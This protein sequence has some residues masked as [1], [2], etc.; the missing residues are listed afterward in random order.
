MRMKKTLTWIAVAVVGVLA[1]AGF[2]VAPALAQQAEDR[3]VDPGP[4]EGRGRQ[5]GGMRL[6]RALDL[7]DEQIEQARALRE[8][9][10]EESSG[11][12]DQVRAEVQA[13]VPRIRN[14]SLTQNDL[15]AAQRRI[16]DLMGQVGEQRA[17]TMYR[18]YQILTPEQRERLGT[19]LEERLEDGRGFGFGMFGDAGPAGAGGFHGRDGMHGPQA[20]RGV[21]DTDRANARPAPAGS[22]A[23]RG[24]RRAA[25]RNGAVFS[26]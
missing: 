26:R 24:E 12:R 14:G 10:R 3:P 6:I 25:G 15:V 17:G 4:R 19:L 2:A 7:T 18:L 13:L 23:G 5:F 8:A 22:R 9:A 20:D 21:A 1:L 16:H 11:V